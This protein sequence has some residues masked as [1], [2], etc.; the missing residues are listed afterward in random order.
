MVHP[1]DQILDGVDNNNIGC[2]TSHG[3]SAGTEGT[4]LFYGVDGSVTGGESH[5]IHLTQEVDC[6]VKERKK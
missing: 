5:L 1:H 6:Y 3:N 2:L 4:M